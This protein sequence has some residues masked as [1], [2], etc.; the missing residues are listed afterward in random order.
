M[1]RKKLPGRTRIAVGM[2]ANQ[3]EF[4]VENNLKELCRLAEEAGRKG[5]DMLATEEVAL[6][7]FAGDKEG[8]Q[9]P[10]PETEKLGEIAAMHSMY[11]ALGLV[12]KG[13]GGAKHNSQI[14]IDRRGKI[15]GVYHKMQL[16]N[17]EIRSGIVPGDEMPVFDTDFGRIAFL[18]CY[19]SQFSEVGRMAGVKGAD[20]IFFPHV[21]GAVGNELIGRAVAYDNTCWTVTV[22]RGYNCF[23]DPRGILVADDN[24]PGKLLIA[25][26]D[27]QRIMLPVNP[28]SL[29]AGW[30]EHQLQ[31]RR[32]HTYADL[33]GPPVT[34]ECQKWPL[35]SENKLEAGAQELQLEIVNRTGEKQSGSVDVQFPLPERIL[36]DEHV[37]WYIKTEL[38]RSDWKPSPKKISFDLAPGEKK[39]VSVKFNVPEDA[40]G[41]ELA[42]ISGKTIGGYP[43]LWQ[44][45]LE[46]YPEPPTLL[47]PRVSSP[48][49]LEK[50]GARVEL[51][52]QFM[53]DPAGAKTVLRLGHDGKALL[54]YAKCRKY[55]P[56][57]NKKGRSPDSLLFAIM[58]DVGVD[59]LFH[60]A[61]HS[62]GRESFLRR[63][64]GASVDGRMP[65]WA[66][67]AERSERIW[68]AA[69]VMPF[70][71][72]E[73]CEREGERSWRFNVQR[74]APL[75]DRLNRERC[76]SEVVY[77]ANTGY[78]EPKRGVEWSVWSVHYSR[79]DRVS[80]LGTLVFD[81]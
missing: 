9:V 54:I 2:V 78:I 12:M 17:G 74:A 67:K 79:I 36:T 11:I 35:Y 23:C 57:D 72:F 48:D 46:R 81:E 27:A 44:R 4:T 1:A 3:A 50:K 64:K 28:Q 55:G 53:N 61:L 24:T 20:I 10:G 66:A 38:G 56:W 22:G 51:A 13:K 43:V 49:E 34:I 80:S 70:D 16:T 73:E 59:R 47:V 7:L 76:M 29:L 60:C 69:I 21:G 14:L 25:D 30:R 32:P 68:S 33:L 40:F 45:K 71:E 63:E 77:P 26:L 18:I 5:C 75:P 15:A 42:R 52:K 37:P 39:P 41:V 8:V 62:D 58:A 6:T 31:E 19:D 65:A